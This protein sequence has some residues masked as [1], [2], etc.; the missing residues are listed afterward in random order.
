MKGG[1]GDVGVIVLQ[2]LGGDTG[3]TGTE[4]IGRWLLGRVEEE[5]GRCGSYLTKYAQT[6][7]AW[8]IAS[9]NVPVLIMSMEPLLPT[10]LVV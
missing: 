5:V 3:A 10:L 4:Q 6:R 1:R 8:H 7:I 2:N 9:K